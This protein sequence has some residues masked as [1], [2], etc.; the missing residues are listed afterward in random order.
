M[1]EASSEASD[2]REDAGPWTEADLCRVDW[3]HGFISR[4]LTEALLR[5]APEGSFLLRRRQPANDDDPI[6]FALSLKSTGAVHHLLIVPNEQN[7]YDLSGGQSFQSVGTFTD[8]ISQQPLVSTDAATG[9]VVQLCHPHLR[10]QDQTP[11]GYR[12]IESIT[13]SPN[14]QQIIES[15][16]LILASKEGFL[17]KEGNV[18]K[19][20][21]RRWF[22]LDG[23]LLSYY[24]PEKRRGPYLGCIDL[25]TV[26]AMNTLEFDPSSGYGLE[27]KTPKR[28]WYI[29]AES[30]EE[31]QS[32]RDALAMRINPTLMR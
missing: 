6:T 31:Q 14:A 19:R 4:H 27:L 13:A 29:L 2:E 32:W 21:R 9:V 12:H 1:S 23:M 5:D 28:V 30:R 24:K 7:G 26:S 8:Y 16:N 22:V 11:H 3:Y 20:L 15:Q 17:Q 18:R 25:T 10:D